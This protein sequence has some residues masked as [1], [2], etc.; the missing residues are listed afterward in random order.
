MTPLNDIAP[1][2]HPVLPLLTIGLAVLGLIMTSIVVSLVQRR[3]A[4][5][6]IDR[7]MEYARQELKATQAA[8]EVPRDILRLTVIRE[9]RE[10]LR[11]EREACGQDEACRQKLL[12]REKELE[13]EKELR[14]EELRLEQSVLQQ[15]SLREQPN[16]RE[17][18]SLQDMK[19]LKFIGGGVVTVPVLLCAL[20]VIIAPAYKDAEKK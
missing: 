18:S 13:A 14:L 2:R 19:V 8:K 12:Q 10:A 4:E 3:Q 20:Y 11:Q 15:A 17:Q 5:V 7:L 6:R 16:L 9:E 1:S